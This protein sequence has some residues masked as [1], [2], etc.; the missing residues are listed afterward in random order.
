MKGNTARKLTVLLGVFIVGVTIG[1][2]T[3]NCGESKRVVGPSVFISAITITDETGQIMGGSD[4]DWCYDAPITSPTTAFA[5]FPAYPNPANGATI[6]RFEIPRSCHVKISIHNAYKGHV[7]TL[8]DHELPSGVHELLW[9]ASS[10]NSG[11]YWCYMWAE[12][13]KCSGRILILQ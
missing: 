7:E 10:H 4:E 2:T 6:I 11:L 13:F 8:M 3:L 12:D 5:M 9:D 1:I